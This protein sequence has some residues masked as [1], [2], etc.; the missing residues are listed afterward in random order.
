MKCCIPGVSKALA[1][2]GQAAHQA[3]LDLLPAIW[4]VRSSVEALAK[5]LD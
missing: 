1:I 5:H 2:A 4:Q 3:G